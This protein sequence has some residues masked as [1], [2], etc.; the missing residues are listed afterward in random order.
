MKYSTE[1]IPA[2]NYGYRYKVELTYS[3]IEIIKKLIDNS[4]SSTPKLISTI[5]YISSLKIIRN[6]FTKLFNHIKN[7]ANY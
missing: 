1:K 5:T 7:E 2:Q 4:Y 3:E 6:G